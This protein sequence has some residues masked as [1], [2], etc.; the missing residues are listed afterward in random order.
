MNAVATSFL[1]AIAEKRSVIFVPSREVARRLWVLT[2]G[3]PTPRQSKMILP[4]YNQFSMIEMWNRNQ[5]GYSRGELIILQ[6]LC[7][8]GVRLEGDQVIW[9]ESPTAHVLDES[10]R[11]TKAQSLA[12]CKPGGPWFQFNESDIP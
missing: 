7:A 9:I 6:G 10:H 11:V 5:R 4:G 8:H 2:Y 1:D 12:R 3:L